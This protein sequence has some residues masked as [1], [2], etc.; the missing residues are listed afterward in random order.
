M[1]KA[2]LLRY[3]ELRDATRRAEETHELHA[4]LANDASDKV[5]VHLGSSVHDPQCRC[6]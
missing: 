6:W 1:G 2:L 5:T 3:S 4:V